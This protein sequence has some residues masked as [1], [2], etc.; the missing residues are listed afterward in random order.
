M[1]VEGKYQKVLARV[2]QIR[3]NN[4]YHHF[5]VFN[6]GALKSGMYTDLRVVNLTNC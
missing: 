4:R 1:V 2:W 6:L 3:E 5:F